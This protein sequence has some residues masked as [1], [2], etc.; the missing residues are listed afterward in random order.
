MSG[1]SKR[2][3]MPFFLFVQFAQNMCQKFYIFKKTE[4]LYN[5]YYIWYNDFILNKQIQER[6]GILIMKGK[7]L[8]KLVSAVSAL[9]MLASVAFVMPASAAEG[10]KTVVYATNTPTWG[11]GGNVRGGT[12]ENFTNYFG[13][14]LADSSVT[15][16]T[17]VTAQ[18]HSTSSADS[19]Q[20]VAQTYFTEAAPSDATKETVEIEMYLNV[21]LASEQ[22][23][24]FC[25]MGEKVNPGGSN[26]NAAATSGRFL[27]FAYD[28]NGTYTV[29]GTTIDNVEF[30]SDTKYKAASTAIDSDK[31]TGLLKYTIIL[32]FLT[33]KADVTIEG[34]KEVNGSATKTY[35]VNF[36]DDNLTTFY[37]FHSR[38]GRY[39]GGC[40]IYNVTVNKVEKAAAT[41]YKVAY[42]V[43]GKSTEE[44]VLDGEKP[45]EIPQ[46]DRTGYIFKGW[47]TD[48]NAE[49][50][51]DKQY[52]STQTIADTA[53][54]KDVTY[55]AVYE[56]N[57]AY[58][59]PVETVTLTGPTTMAIGADSSTAA[60]NEYKVA[61]AGEIGGDILAN[62]D[63]RVTDFDVTWEFLGFKTA[64]DRPEQYC[65]SYGSVETSGTAHSTATFKLRNMPFNFY[66][67]VQ[68]TVTYNGATVKS[69]PI[70][71]VVLGNT[72][73]PTNQI[74]PLGGYPSDFDEYAD[75]LEGYTAVKDT[76]ASL[77]DNIISNGS[78]SGSD[79]GG[80]ATIMKE[81]SNKFLRI[82]APTVKK[83][84]MYTYKID[85]PS[86]QVV[87]EQNVRFNAIGGSITLTSGYPFWSSNTG[88]ANPVTLEFTGSAL[89]LNNENIVN[90][91]NA[92]TINQGVWYK[93]VLSV[94]KSNETCYAVIYDASGNFVGEAKNVAW[95]E[96]SAP[97]YYSVGF[98]S[99][100]Y[101][102]TI[103]FD[104]YKAYYAEADV[105]TYQLN[106]SQTSLSIPNG[107]TADLSASLKTKDGYDMTA[108]AEWTVLEEDMKEGVIITPDASDSHKA[109]VTL[110]EGAAPG[111]ATVQVNIGGNPKT[112][113]LNITSSAQNVKFLES[114]ASIGI[115]L[116]PSAH[117][118]AVYKA[119]VASGTGETLSTDVTYAIYDKSN[120][121]PYTL[122][123]GITFDASTGTITVDSTAVPATFSI[124]ATG[125]D[126]DSGS[127][128]SRAVTVTVHGSFYDFGKDTDEAVAE[129]YTAVTKDTLYTDTR[130][131]GIVGTAEEKGTDSTTDPHSDYLE[132]RIT[133]KAKVQPKKV[134]S[135]ELTYQGAAS[136][137]AVNGDLDGA[138][139][140]Q[141]DELTADELAAGATKLTTS[142]VTIPVVDDVLDLT[143]LSEYTTTDTKGNKTVHSFGTPKIASI[144]IIKL[145]DKTPTEKPSVRHIGDSTAANK[146][147]WAY[148]IDHNRSQFPELDALA[149]FYNQG[150]GGRNLTTY[151]QEG[152]LLGVL[153]SINPGDIVI[154]GNNGTNGMGSYFEDDVNYYL[155]AAEAF[156]AKIIINSYTPHGAVG[157]YAN[158]YNSSTHTFN[159][160]RQDSYDV[161]VRKVAEERAAN[162][163]NYI[164]FVEIGKN[165]DA[166]FNAYVAA[167]AD[168]DAAAQEIISCF[169]DHNHYSNDDKA[170]ELMLNGYGDIKGIVAQ[171]VEL[172][173][174]E[175]TYDVTFTVD[176]GVKSV[177]ISQTGKPDKK[178][179]D[180]TAPVALAAGDYTFTVE[181]TGA[182]TTVTAV[183]VGGTAV[184]ANAFTVADAA[185]AIAITTETTIVPPEPGKVLEAAV[186]AEPNAA[187]GV[188]TVTLKNT[189]DA[190]AK[191]AVVVV[192]RDTNGVLKG[193]S[194][195]SV[196]LASGTQSQDVTT[197]A[198]TVVGAPTLYIWNMTNG[199]VP[200]L[201][202]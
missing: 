64:N 157:G 60:D 193:I 79:D 38:M 182:N 142:T 98:G 122:P 97:V 177:T 186:K 75:D 162:D 190:D 114:V 40:A 173:T 53:V 18:A 34:T 148:Y 51:S 119:V 111:P 57:A 87:F 201:A 19:G 12:A 163:P 123:D 189:T 183:T 140:G 195:K 131:Y 202:D 192:T 28:K 159:T 92:A 102:G 170:R 166:A 137:E 56:K 30:K 101:T 191:I 109:T 179:T 154:F 161:T 96:S 54:N 21:A 169:S 85:T 9:S 2:T 168:P 72:A 113:E 165:A 188:A 7:L 90:G 160:W 44:M 146:G 25:V 1:N 48:G 200:M 46:T 105:S 124:R 52:V 26:G 134:Y 70:Y 84:H 156:G 65:D 116:D 136:F 95:K 4:K 33:K 198:I 77:T 22:V 61:I 171:L 8:R 126:T 144:K 67:K 58:I 42:S 29:N 76:Y 120:T 151:Y 100:D 5:L 184:S 74:L 115:P 20:R 81:D 139:M 69:N 47:T 94:D 138:R 178:I 104:N 83:S 175:Q 14:D 82:N 62:P 130:G 63:S 152:K 167:A 23:S 71:A 199:M 181:T 185:V 80:S 91:E 106:A 149:T 153:S 117:E 125:K 112:I 66:G 103:D 3:A 24:T 172:L 16:P 35:T 132:G 187:T 43:N 176:A 143:L 6:R 78:M 197:D 133:F 145:D 196:A 49:Y 41:Y 180:F 37:G 135:V 10:D 32:D 121:N 11:T 194:F 174:P 128:I 129:N 155:D 89:A 27:E 68:A 93:V 17:G 127:D 164:G 88:Y 73:K 36:L 108:A 45:Q 147:S 110:A 15:E 86:T 118:T 50:D 158:G 55:T 150:A 107:D 31:A 141:S 13:K 59:E 39:R 99:G